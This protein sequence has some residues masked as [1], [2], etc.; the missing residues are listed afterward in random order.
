MIVTKTIIFQIVRRILIQIRTYRELYNVLQQLEQNE[1][2][3]LDADITVYDGQ[4]DEYHQAEFN[5]GDNIS[6]RPLDNFH[7]FLAFPLPEYAGHNPF[8]DGDGESDQE[9]D[10]YFYGP[11]Q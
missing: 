3:W 1:S 11:D 9:R 6:D 7:P 4:T 2:E 10:F 5:L 8:R